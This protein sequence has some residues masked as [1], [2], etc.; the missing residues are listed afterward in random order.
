[1]QHISP[2][3]EQKDVQSYPQTDNQRLPTE[4]Q[5]LDEI[6]IF[7]STNPASVQSA[8]SQILEKSDLLLTGRPDTLHVT[9]Q[10]LIDTN[11]YFSSVSSNSVSPQNLVTSGDVASG[12][13]GPRSDVK[14]APP[15]PPRRTRDQFCLSS[16]NELV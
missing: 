3:S 9:P 13:H 14:P 6:D 2:N 15:R 5:F 16:K 11:I 4:A 12:R 10:Q 1:M 8:S 7:K